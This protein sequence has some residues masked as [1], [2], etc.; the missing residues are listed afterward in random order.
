MVNLDP[1]ESVIK[2]IQTVKEFSEGAGFKI[3]K[4]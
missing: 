1:R 3:N 2:L 4:S